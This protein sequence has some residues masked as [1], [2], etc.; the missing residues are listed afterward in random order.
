[1]GQDPANG[2]QHRTLSHT[3]QKSEEGTV[4]ENRF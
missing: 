3:L 1:M 2:P 4:S